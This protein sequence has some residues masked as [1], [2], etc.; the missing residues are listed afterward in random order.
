LQKTVSPRG[1]SSRKRR[2]RKKWFAAACKVE[3]ESKK[4]EKL[5]SSTEVKASKATA[6]AKE[7]RLKLA[8]VINTISEGTPLAA[9][10]IPW[11]DTEHHSYKKSKGVDSQSVAGVA[12]PSH[13]YLSPQR[14]GMTA[15]KRLSIGSP[16]C[17]SDHREESL[18]SNSSSVGSLSKGVLTISDD[19]EDGESGYHLVNRTL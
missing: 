3:R 7:L 5:I 12:V 13:L 9:G 15:N 14:K 16:G 10:L 1:C 17:F 19:R 11:Q 2:R 6:K 4:Q 18:S 8:A